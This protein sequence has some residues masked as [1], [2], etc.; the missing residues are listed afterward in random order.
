MYCLSEITEA[1]IKNYCKS[2]YLPVSIKKNTFSKEEVLKLCYNFTALINSYPDDNKFVYISDDF[3]KDIDLAITLLMRDHC[4]LS[5]NY[6]VMPNGI[7]QDGVGFIYA[8]QTTRY[9]A[10]GKKLPKK[11]NNKIIEIVD[12]RWDTR[13]IIMLSKA[14][15]KNPNIEK[16]MYFTANENGDYYCFRVSVNTDE[17]LGLAFN[18]Y[19]YSLLPDP[20]DMYDIKHTYAFTENTKGD[21]YR[22]NKL[23]MGTVFNTPEGT[24]VKVSPVGTS[25]CKNL[26]NGA[27]DI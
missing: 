5:D 24:L 3:I 22:L 4:H 19:F 13:P 8:G 11:L 20:I 25:L 2:S 14:Y 18:T 12:A 7:I 16:Y 23:P 6:S 9:Y 26:F 10:I 21:K 1:I 17:E 27:I 15:K